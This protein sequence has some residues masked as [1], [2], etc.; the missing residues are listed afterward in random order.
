[1]PPTEFE[2]AILSNE[3]PQ[4]DALDRAVTRIVRTYITKPHLSLQCL[5][6]VNTIDNVPAIGFAQQTTGAVLCGHSAAVVLR[7]VD[8]LYVI[9]DI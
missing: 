7:T 9:R 1:M 2:F 3:R 8:C 6:H 5:H 4:T